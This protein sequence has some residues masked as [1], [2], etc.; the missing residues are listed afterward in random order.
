MSSR[1]ETSLIPGAFSP[2]TR[3]SLAVVDGNQVPSVEGYGPGHRL[4]IVQDRPPTPRR[5]LLR[6]ESPAA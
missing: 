1:V 3:L 5:R 6:W 2:R 4:T